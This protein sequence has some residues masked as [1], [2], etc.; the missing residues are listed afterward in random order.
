MDTPH[1]LKK[2]LAPALLLRL[3]AALDNGVGR[4]PAMGVNTWNSFRCTDIKAANIK[5][6]ADRLVELGLRELGY[7]YVNVDDCWSVGRNS[8]TKELMPDPKSFPQGMREVS[9]YIHALGLKF[10]I[11]GDRG[12]QTCAG[13][14]GSAGF[15]ELDAATYAAWGVDYL[16]QDS[17]WASSDHG[18][19]F[20]QYSAMR[21]ALNST[22]RHILLSLCG[23]NAWYAPHGS[24]MGN[25]WRIAADSDDWP[26][27]YVAARTSE[28][29]SQYSAP[30]GFNDPDMLVG[31]SSS[32]AISVTEQQQRTQFSLWAIMSAPLLIG[33]NLM[34]IS[35]HDLD[36]LR[37]KD[38][39]DINQDTLVDFGRVTPIAS[40][41]PPY[42]PRE[43]NQYRPW[44]YPVR[45]STAVST[46]LMI[47]A[48]VSGIFCSCFVM[49]LSYIRHF[50]HTVSLV[51]EGAQLEEIEHALLRRGEAS[52]SC[53]QVNLR[54]RCC[55]W[56]STFCI[57]MCG[58]L[59]LLGICSAI[60]IQASIDKVDAC[61]QTWARKLSTNGGT[62]GA[63]LL[64]NW[65]PEDVQREW[66]DVACMQS[67]GFPQ[68]ACVLD[69]WARTES[70]TTV[71]RQPGR[72]R[73][74]ISDHVAGNGGSI[75]YRLSSSNMSCFTS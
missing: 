72:W 20:K 6:Y 7:V 37:N 4:T 67:L 25:S 39:I 73:R 41:C 10:G 64:V 38:V 52:E 49:C 54:G 74:S 17:C 27:I 63:I 34:T 35:Q 69:L 36:T 43:Q 65:A 9:D 55:L 70:T 44:F 40:T 5:A 46:M 68:G 47:G 12:S 11:Y 22:G 16:K 62:D 1:L 71:I 31:S 60:W 13:R 18:T 2:W 19:A 29:L 28:G 53:L 66:C 50:K 15:E 8:T 24:Q 57:G 14:S 45:Q 26:H 42:T 61:Q 33:S 58:L 75:L 59:A 32:N 3:I 23:W 30:G 51:E 21:D 56:T 48:V